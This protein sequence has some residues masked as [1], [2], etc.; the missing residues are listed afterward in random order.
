MLYNFNFIE[1]AVSPEFTNRAFLYG[2]GLF[3]TM[4]LKEGKV[5]FLPD[6]WERLLAGTAAFKMQLPQ[7]FTLEYLYSSIPILAERTGLGN[8]ARVKL[9]VWRKAGGLFTPTESEAE[10]AIFVYP[11]SENAQVIKEKV[12]FYEDV[13]LHFSSISSYKTCSALP[14]VMAGIA[15]K[16]RQLDDIVLFDVYGN[17]AE[18]SVSNIFWLKNG[19]LF[20]PAIESGCIAGVMRKQLLSKANELGIKVIEGLFPTIELL[21]AEAVLTCNVAGIQQIRQIEGKEFALDKMPE[22]LLAV[23]R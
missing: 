14:Y 12:G 11:L 3:E 9:Q 2:D 19:Q 7:G 21:E 20:T 16:E 23:G 13:R 22:E 8:N 5:R 1:I 4:L 10:W 6:H 17:I 15:K 18:C